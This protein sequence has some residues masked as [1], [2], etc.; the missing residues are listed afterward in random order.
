MWLILA[1]DVQD[2]GK[3]GLYQLSEF[4]ADSDHIS[5]KE[6]PHAISLHRVI[7]NIQLKDR[8]REEVYNPFSLFY[9]CQSTYSVT[10][11]PQILHTS[12]VFVVL[13]GF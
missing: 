9:F 1:Q 2:R 3:W 13:A 8:H 4:S 5:L 7:F 11:Y 10:I 6:F 12:T